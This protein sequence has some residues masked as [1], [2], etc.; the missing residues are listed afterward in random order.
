MNKPR[1]V[2]SSLIWLFLLF[3]FGAGVTWAVF[4]M[5]ILGPERGMTYYFALSIVIAAEFVI[6][7][8]LANPGAR[9]GGKASSPAT[10]YM[11]QGG[12][13]VW[14]ILTLIVAAFA[15]SPSRADTAAADKILLIDLVLTFVLL[16]FLY[17][18]YAK[19]FEI[20][21][22]TQQLADERANIQFDIPALEQVMRFTTD[23]GQQHSE[24]AALS[25]R[26]GKK[27]DTVRSAIDGVMVSESAMLQGK[28]GDWPARIQEQISE[29]V[30]NFDDVDISSDQALER[31]NNISKQADTILTT[32][33]QRERAITS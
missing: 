21:G 32:L 13:F 24:H 15:V 16:V 14:F 30:G 23:I 6:F 20:G 31:L 12:I 3:L 10:R 17:V 9:A 22:I 18:I 26:V 27:V 2:F 33:R 29:L 7:L 11:A 8:H 19:D 25:D 5:F 28:G 1:S 4:S